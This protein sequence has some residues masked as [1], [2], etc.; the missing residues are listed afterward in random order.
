MKYYYLDEEV[1]AL[2][3]D[4]NW[5]RREDHEAEVAKLRDIAQ[6]DGPVY[7]AGRDE[8]RADVAAQL[9]AILDPDDLFHWNLD[10][11]LK[12]VAQ[13]AAPGYCSAVMVDD[14]RARA[15]KAEADAKELRRYDARK[16]LRCPK[17]GGW[18]EVFIDSADTFHGLCE[19][20]GV[21]TLS[22]R[23]PLEALLAW[24]RGNNEGR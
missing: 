7:Q 8:G 21:R 12:K 9:R 2:S 10:G 13:L 18:A 19:I 1:V 17:C 5:V 3:N 6:T 14:L 20:C 23:T 11:V 22:T 24:H 4:G 16:L 15:E